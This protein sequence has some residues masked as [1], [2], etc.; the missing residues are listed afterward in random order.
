MV[1]I[2]RS[3]VIHDDAL[4]VAI[5]MLRV[6]AGKRSTGAMNRC[7]VS[8]HGAHCKKCRGNPE[9]NPFRT[10]RWLN[11][12]CIVMIRHDESLWFIMMT[13]HDSSWWFIMM[14][15]MMHRHESASWWCTIAL[16]HEDSSK[17]FITMSH[18]DAWL[19]WCC[20]WWC[21]IS[22]HHDYTSWWGILMIH[23]EAWSR[24]IT[25]WP[26]EASFQSC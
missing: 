17:G 13:H 3:P 11:S 6:P 24:W 1:G 25:L 16:Q 12:W 18:H 9:R 8:L 5:P 23:H 7:L 4:A 22:M 14:I 26:W 19:W 2:A 10:T 15:I 20:W 21:I